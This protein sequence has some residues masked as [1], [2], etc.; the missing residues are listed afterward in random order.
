MWTE[1]NGNVHCYRDNQC[2]YDM[3]NVNNS[4]FSCN[5]GYKVYKGDPS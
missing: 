5:S 1:S 4:C 2:P 3:Y